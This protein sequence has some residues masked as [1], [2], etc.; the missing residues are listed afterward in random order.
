MN[1]HV[2]ATAVFGDE[3]NVERLK[4]IIECGKNGMSR[5]ETAE[6][7]GLHYT[8]LSHII[9]G[10]E[11]PFKD[12]R[13]GPKPRG[14]KRGVHSEEVKA[15]RRRNGMALDE[16]AGRRTS[17]DSRVVRAAKSLVELG[18]APVDVAKMYRVEVRDL[19]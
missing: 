19:R 7:L 15:M 5:A 1:K 2:S 9:Q 6:E 16:P 17:L 8:V 13:R 14:H 11:I 12:V 4:T 3:I 10:L 18:Y